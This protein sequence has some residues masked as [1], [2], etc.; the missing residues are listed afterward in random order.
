LPPLPSSADR[1]RILAGLESSRDKFQQ[2][3]FYL[4]RHGDSYR[5]R[6]EAYIAESDS[7][8]TLR[9]RI[10]YRGLHWIFWNKLSVEANGRVATL[11]VPWFDVKRDMSTGIEEES[12]DMPI[13]SAAKDAYELTVSQDVSA[14]FG[15]LAAAKTASVRLEGQQIEDRALQPE[16]LHKF[17][18]VAR[19]FMALYGIRDDRNSLPGEPS[20]AKIKI[21]R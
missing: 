18:D 12:V 5:S 15:L 19:R 1:K 9:I 7:G 16:E 2:V 3:T 14:V 6:I 21:S 13:A 4:A 10:V 17:Q 11:S 8:Y 20:R